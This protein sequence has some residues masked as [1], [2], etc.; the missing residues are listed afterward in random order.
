MRKSFDVFC[1]EYDELQ[2]KTSMLAPHKRILTF[3]EYIKKSHEMI[4]GAMDYAYSFEHNTYKGIPV[5]MLSQFCNIL[6]FQAEFPYYA[7][8]REVCE[9]DPSKLP[10]V[11]YQYERLYSIYEKYVGG[12]GTSGICYFTWPAL[13]ALA[14]NDY[15]QLESLLPFS[16]GMQTR[17]PWV[18]WQSANLLLAIHYKKPEFIHYCEENIEQ[19]MKR[20][21]ESVFALAIRNS[22]ADIF[23]KDSGAF[24]QDLENVCKGWTRRN[25]DYLKP[26]DKTV[27]CLEAIGLY[28]LAKASF[29]EENRAKLRM[30]ESPVFWPELAEFSQMPP[31]EP[32]HVYT[33]NLSFLNTLLTDAKTVT[34]KERYKVPVND[35]EFM[36]EYYGRLIQT[37]WEKIHQ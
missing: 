36:T 34:V 24:N 2:E 20:E 33:G 12:G 6:R 18:L 25:M 5:I 16:I 28:H 10:N 21:K 27:V 13:Q 19:W 26:I 7:A 29:D 17:G 14:V 31:M 8:L 3:P 22:L 37:E 23:R 35:N 9:N 30:P 32:Y 4:Q 1:R 11:V 15:E